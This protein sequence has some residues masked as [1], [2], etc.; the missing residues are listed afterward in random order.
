MT[1]WIAT[2]SKLASFVALMKVLPARAAPLVEPV[3]RASSGPG[4][5]GIVAVIAAVT[6]TYGNFAALAQR[7][8]K[9]MLA[10]SSI[11][12]AGYI[13]VGVAAAGVSIDESERRRRGPLLLGGLCLRNVGAF[14][15]AAWLV[16]DKD[17]DDIDDLNGLGFQE[18]LPG[19]LHPGADALADRHAAAG[20]VLRQALHVHGG[21]RTSRRRPSRSP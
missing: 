11:A 15:V 10:Y 4:W 7:N 8:F 12:H 14:A 18:P 13:L 1:A 9:R 16:R 21:A 2:G 20:G 5:I 17:S 3:R 19:D 6:M